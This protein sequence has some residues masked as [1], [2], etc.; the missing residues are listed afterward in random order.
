MQ[1]KKQQAAARS[2]VTPGAMGGAG[3]F[4]KEVVTA[5]TRTHMTHFDVDEH[6][7]HK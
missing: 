3:D 1:G 4:G 7:N 5:H 2:R 6:T